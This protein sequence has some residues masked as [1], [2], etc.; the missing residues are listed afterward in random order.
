[1]RDAMLKKG[2]RAF[3]RFHAF[4]GRQVAD[5]DTGFLQ[6]DDISAT[7]LH[8]DGCPV[9]L[10]GWIL[11]RVVFH[12]SN[13]TA[14]G[15]CR[16]VVSTDRDDHR[17]VPARHSPLEVDLRQLAVPRLHPRNCLREPFFLCLLHVYTFGG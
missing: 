8:F 13:H 5:V 1:M 14:F 10:N 15:I 2:E 6:A 7:K 11:N 9:N 3:H 17:V 12:C 16:L 4:D